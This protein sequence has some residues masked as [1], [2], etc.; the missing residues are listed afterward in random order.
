MLHSFINRGDYKGPFPAIQSK[1]FMG[2]LVQF[3]KAIVA[4]IRFAIT[5]TN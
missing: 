3:V 4:N 2:P 5:F 1:K